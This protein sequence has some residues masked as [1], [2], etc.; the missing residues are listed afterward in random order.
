MAKPVT[1]RPG[2]AADKDLLVELLH[3]QHEEHR[4]DTPRADLERA[5]VAVLDRPDRGALFICEADG[6]VVGGA[7][8]S[9][10]WSLEHGG[11]AGWVE[12]M[13]VR[14]AHRGQGYGAALL[15]AACAWARK[16]GCF[17]VDLEIAAD[18][19]RA[20]RLY[21]RE[22]FRLLPRTRWVRRLE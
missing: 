9:L 20:A 22:G 14:P 2:T 8:I 18:H 21:A 7:Y 15:G 17:A 5:L 19:A 16:Q 1:V 13:Y 4:I 12:E 6:D 11:L 10:T 3:A